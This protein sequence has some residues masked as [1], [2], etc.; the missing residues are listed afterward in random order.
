MC[1]DF[2]LCYDKKLGPET[3]LNSSRS[4]VAS[5]FWETGG[6]KKRN[7]PKCKKEKRAE[8]GNVEISLRYGIMQCF[9]QRD[10][11]YLFELL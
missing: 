3:H 8:C 9:I 11:M 2:I 7:Q 10:A 1:H 6:K 4:N 5:A